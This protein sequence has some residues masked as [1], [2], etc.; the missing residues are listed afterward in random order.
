MDLRTKALSRSEQLH[1]DRRKRQPSTE[2]L[3][4]STAVQAIQMPAEVDA[5]AQYLGSKRFRAFRQSVSAEV[6][7]QFA[8]TSNDKRLLHLLLEGRPGL[9]RRLFIPSI[10]IP[11][12][13]YCCMEMNSRCGPVAFGDT[14]AGMMT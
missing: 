8:P 5:W 4:S 7:S 12:S 13:A 11:N 14:G 6:E 1:P 2:L 9:F 3:S 10:P